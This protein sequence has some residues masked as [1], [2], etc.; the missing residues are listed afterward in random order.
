MKKTNGIK[1]NALIFIKLSLVLTKEEI[2][3]AKKYINKEQ[4]R[5]VKQRV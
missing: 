2:L 3:S 5:D 4:I 1:K